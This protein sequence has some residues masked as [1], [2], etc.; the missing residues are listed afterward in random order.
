MLQ[1]LTATTLMTIITVTTMMT[2]MTMIIQFF[3]CNMLTKHI[4]EPVTESAQTIKR[5][6][7][8]YEK[9]VIAE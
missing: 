7:H 9:N 1:N 8:T 5:K 3:I 4:Q 2:T 6:I